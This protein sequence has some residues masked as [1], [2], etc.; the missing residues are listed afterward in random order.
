MAGKQRQYEKNLRRMAEDYGPILLS[1]LT[2]EERV[3]GLSPEEI[4][5][6]LD[7]ETLEKLK[8]LLNG[9]GKQN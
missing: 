6:G 7:P 2:P 5:R 9:Q 3:R 8:Q 1:A 4:L